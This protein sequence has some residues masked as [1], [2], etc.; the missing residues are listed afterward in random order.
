[1][2][3]VHGTPPAHI[4]ISAVLSSVRPHSPRSAMAALNGSVGVG[5]SVM[6]SRATEYKHARAGMSL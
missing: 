1:M 3:P 4:V 2:M 5:L 6:M